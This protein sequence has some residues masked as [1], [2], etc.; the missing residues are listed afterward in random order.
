MAIKH[1]EECCWCRVVAVSP[2]PG[3]SVKTGAGCAGAAFSC[4]RQM[5]ICRLEPQRR[6]RLLRNDG[7]S[8]RDR[9]EGKQK[10]PRGARWQALHTSAQ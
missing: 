10:P 7:R 2:V 8:R 3:T 1:A 5:A 4:C 6:C 9:H